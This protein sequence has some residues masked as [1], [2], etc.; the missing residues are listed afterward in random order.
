MY[1][2]NR[3]RKR[4]TKTSM[5]DYTDPH[6]QVPLTSICCSFRFLCYQVLLLDPRDKVQLSTDTRCND[7][8][9]GPKKI[10][11]RDGGCH[12]WSSVR[13]RTKPNILLLPF[14]SIEYLFVPGSTFVI[15]PFFNT[16]FSVNG[17]SFLLLTSHKL[18]G[19]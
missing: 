2:G 15:L 7:R 12:F 6:V 4:K 9:L 10:E 19:T 11:Q 5:W 13:I 16:C 3:Q 8:S 1:R 14:T 18:F 17:Y